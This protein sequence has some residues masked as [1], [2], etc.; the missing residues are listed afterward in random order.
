MLKV[1]EKIRNCD[2]IK[3]SN[4]YTKATNF[5]KELKPKI[6][7]PIDLK[8]GTYISY[9]VS[10]V[11]KRFP[12]K[13]RVF[14]DRKSAD[15]SITINFE[16]VPNSPEQGVTNNGKS[17]KLFKGGHSSEYFYISVFCYYEF[18]G[19]IGVA[20]KGVDVID[21]VKHEKYE[22]FI[23]YEDLKNELYE[24]IEE[25]KLI[26]KF[27]ESNKTKLI[28]DEDNEEKNKD[29]NMKG[30]SNKSIKDHI[31]NISRRES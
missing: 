13:V 23:D 4:Y 22:S 28:N 14:T 9:K 3:A 26:I 20:F 16:K 24:G 29:E 18:N 30:L 6:L 15:M 10:T 2:E 11:N 19:H 25:N 12:A 27:L 7:T 5:V 17:F 31:K 21:K 1:V 8:S